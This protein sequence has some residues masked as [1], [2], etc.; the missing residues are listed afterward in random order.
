MS[1]TAVPEPIRTPL[2]LE[3]DLK[4]TLKTTPNRAFE[5]G[6]AKEQRAAQRDC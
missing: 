5:S 6:R 3:T 2:A 1:A 4:P